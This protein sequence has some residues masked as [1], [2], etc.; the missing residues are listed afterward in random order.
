MK[1]SGDLDAVGVL[2]DI[3]CGKPILPISG[4]HKTILSSDFSDDGYHLATGS[5]DN[6]VKIWDLRRR[7][8]TNTLP[9]HTKLISWVKY[10]PGF[11]S[12]LLTCSYDGFVKVISCSDYLEKYSLNIPKARISSLSASADMRYLYLTTIEKKWYRYKRAV[13][14]PSGGDGGMFASLGI[15]GGEDGVGDGKLMKSTTVEG[16]EG[17]DGDDGEDLLGDK[18]FLANLLAG[19]D[20][21]F[22]GLGEVIGGENEGDGAMEIENGEK[23]A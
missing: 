17:G 22:D 7:S 19:I 2:W 10:Q 13:K 4:H 11:S 20:N 18:N 5:K 14:R 8:C 6:T 12:F 15:E 21:D 3:R 1:F 9:I 23:E 16:D